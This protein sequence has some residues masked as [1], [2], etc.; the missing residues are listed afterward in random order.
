MWGNERVRVRGAEGEGSGVDD[1]E[2]EEKE[3]GFGSCTCSCWG[4]WGL[5]FDCVSVCDWN[6]GFVLAGKYCWEVVL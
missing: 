2:E 1:E 5:G 4:C 6:F 3:E